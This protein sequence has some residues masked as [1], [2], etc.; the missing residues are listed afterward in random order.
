MA[1]K[2]DWT[3]EQIVANLTRDRVAWPTAGPVPFSFY[4][5]AHG[6][7][8]RVPNFSAFSPEQR[9]ATRTALDLIADVA[10]IRFVEAADNGVKPGAGNERLS[11]FTLNSPTAPFWGS[12]QTFAPDPPPFGTAPIQGV[13]VVINMHRAGAQGGWGPGDSNVRKLTH[14]LL[15]GLGLPHPGEYNGDGANYDRDA[16]YRQDSQQY[17][18]MSYWDAAL[19]GANHSVGGVLSFAATPQL[20]DVAALQVIYGANT[21]TRMGDTVYGFNANAGRAAFD[22]TVN[23]RPVVTLWDGGGSTPWTCRA[24]RR[25]RAWTCVRAPSAT[26]A[27]R[28]RTSPSPS[29]C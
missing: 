7:L 10:H 19:T 15:H 2:P 23:T 4:E 20:H 24:S 9:E 1:D 26:Q 17:T 28:R 22:F 27:E 6:F 5:Q 8:G 21:A 3:F 16:A 14:E 12:A 29:A 11:L 25:L 13:Q 18:M